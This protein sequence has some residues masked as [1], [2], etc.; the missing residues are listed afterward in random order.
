MGNAET[1]RRKTRGLL[2]HESARKYVMNDIIKKAQQTLESFLECWM[3]ENYREME[4]HIQ[5]TWMNGRGDK[6]HEHLQRMFSR[7]PLAKYEIIESNH[8]AE[9]RIDF[10]VNVWMNGSKTPKTIEKAVVICEF[11]PYEPSLKGDWGVNPVSMLR[12]R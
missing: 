7:R 8:T 12:I 5:L 6:L 4:N 10:R 3:T 9:C 11:G 2:F 1:H